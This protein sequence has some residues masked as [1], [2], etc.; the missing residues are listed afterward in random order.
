[1]KPLKYRPHHFLCTIGFQGKGYSPSFVENFQ[2]IADHLRG[3][4]GEETPIEVVRETDSICHP[5]PNRTGTTCTSE[6]KIRALDQAHQHMLGLK[7]GEILTWAEAQERIVERVD[8]EGF[9]RACAPC[10]WKAL[11]VC[12]SALRELRRKKGVK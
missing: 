7:V 5:C 3:P 9:D 8:D 12:E 2:A 6:A 1:M 11:G 4:A 10:A